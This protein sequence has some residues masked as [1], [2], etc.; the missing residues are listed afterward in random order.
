MRQKWLSRS[1]QRGHMPS[2]IVAFTVRLFVI[3]IP[4]V[5]L[6]AELGVALTLSHLA[7]IAL[8]GIAGITWVRRRPSVPLDLA[9]F[10]ILAFL[11]V[12]AVTVV[13][14][15][16]EPNIEMIG[17]TAHAKS[18]K[19]FIGLGFGTA[20]FTA[21]YF[22]LRWYGLG[23][24]AL[25]THYWTTAVFAVL[26]LAQYA[27]ALV[28]IDSPLANLPVHNST[29]GVTRPLSLMY[30]FPR[31]SLTLVEPS[32]LATYLLTGWALWLFALDRP[33]VESNRAR[34]WFTVSGCVLTVALVITGSRLAYV[35]FGA[36]TITAL[37]VRPLRLRR[38][39][40][41]GV[42]AVLG[43]MLTGPAYSRAIVTS[44]LPK[45]LSVETAVEADDAPDGS[46]RGGRGTSATRRA[47]GRSAVS[48][49]QSA[50]ATQDISVQ[51]RMASYLV[52]MTMM[53]QRPLLGS[54]VGTS[55][56]YMER[57]WPPTFS[58]L[59]PTRD[60]AVTMLSHYATVATETGLLGLACLVT[61]AVAVGLSLVKVGRLGP[62]ARVLA[63]GIGASIAGYCITS[64]A[65]ALVVYQ[66]LLV[67]LLPAVALA[68]AARPTAATARPFEDQLIPVTSAVM[69]SDGVRVAA[70]GSGTPRKR[71]TAL[72]MDTSESGSNV[73]AGVTRSRT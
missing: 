25:R 71:R 18:V 55:G 61:F 9:V 45:Y 49:M 16:F 69:N 36:L 63:W 26:V 23:L 4:L 14:V 21:L 40:L 47:R 19:Q 10:S 54:G 38:A 13:R 8:I 29:L 68:L 6:A 64:L 60:S 43:L 24:T 27:V 48:Q 30:G 66:V 56:F 58:P 7:G 28:D 17:E 37:L 62:D 11:L 22:L 67:W 5:G 53:K 44:L 31:V 51:H 3:S 32:T 15:Q 73:T 33:P 42:S 57:Y 20:V 39:L 2:H 41:V 12:A 34:Q 59:P 70:G 72:A 35:A 46:S 65:T 1:G 52:A 50:V